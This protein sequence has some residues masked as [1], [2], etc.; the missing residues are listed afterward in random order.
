[1]EEGVEEED[2]FG[3]LHVITYTYSFNFL[4]LQYDVLQF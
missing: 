1:V 2:E 4:H 3:G